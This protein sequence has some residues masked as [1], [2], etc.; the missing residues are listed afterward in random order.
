[1]GKEFWNS[2]DIGAL[3]ALDAAWIQQQLGKPGF[4]L[5]QTPW[6]KEDQ[7]VGSNFHCLFY[8]CILW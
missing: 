5:L 2:G 1:M 7:H 6:R 8:S 3:L 4:Q